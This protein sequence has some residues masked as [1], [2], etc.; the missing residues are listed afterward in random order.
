[1]PDAFPFYPVKTMI[2][3]GGMIILKDKALAEKLRL[4]KAFGVTEPMAKE[5]FRVEYADYV[6]T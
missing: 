1:M 3:E 5:A 6:W 4:L 2:A